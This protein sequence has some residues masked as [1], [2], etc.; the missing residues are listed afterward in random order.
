MPLVDTGIQALGGFAETDGMRL[1]KFYSCLKKGEGGFPTTF[2]GVEV[3]R[4]SLTSCKIQI[5]QSNFHLRAL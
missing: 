3:S 1:P 4:L 2:Q 5:P